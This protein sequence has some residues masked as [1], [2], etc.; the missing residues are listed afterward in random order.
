MTVPSV[1]KGRSAIVTG[2]SQGLGR[3]IAES[4]V[5]SGAD[6]LLMARDGAELERARDEIASRA[7]A[8]PRVHASAG[9]VSRPDDCSAAVDRAV[10][11]FGGLT[12]LVNNAG[13]YGPLGRLEDVDWAQWEEAVRVNLMGTALMCRA[14][15]R[16][17]RAR[18]YGKIVNLSGGGASSPLP[19]FSAYAASKAAVVRLTETL[20]G[21]LRDD[22]IDVNAIAP[23]PLNTRL[24]DQVLEAGPDKVGSE[25]HER[26]VQ[27]RAAGGVPLEKGAALAA[28]LASAKSDGITGRLLSAVWDDWE[29]LP[30]RRDALAG[31]DVFTLRRI[32]P[33]DR[34]LPW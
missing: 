10:S 24:L 20:A 15:I 17:M 26:A 33:K 4:F 34:G 32:V 5:R 23:G 29:R 11:L 16:P 14:A 2:A 8:G 22:R 28:F 6:V 25:F 27:Q 12:V 13:V 30:E 18:G 7:P 1:L 3:A 19:R 31:G 21:E 9:D